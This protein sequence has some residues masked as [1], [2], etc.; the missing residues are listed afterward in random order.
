MIKCAWC[1]EALHECRQKN[2]LA[3]PKFISISALVDCVYAL[4]EAGN[5]WYNGSTN[6]WKKLDLI[7]D[8]DSK[9]SIE[10]D[11]K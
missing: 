1:N 5:V 3:K 6:I 4:D 10:K 9:Q 2:P 11:E 8:T 7:F